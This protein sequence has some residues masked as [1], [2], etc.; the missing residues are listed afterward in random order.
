M[1]SSSITAA[2]VGSASVGDAIPGSS[3]GGELEVGTS[4]SSVAVPQAEKII[5]TIN[6]KTVIIP[7]FIAPLNISKMI[8]F[9][10][11][12]LAMNVHENQI[13]GY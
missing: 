2:S 13:C 4:G 10:H 11:R 8:S 3:A 12:V 9:P 5:P 1:E 6:K 7:D